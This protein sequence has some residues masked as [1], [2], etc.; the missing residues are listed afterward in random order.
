MKTEE[1]LLA[2]LRTVNKDIPDNPDT[3]LLATHL[4]DSFDMVNLVSDIEEE[5][6]I[7]L[8][9]EDIVPEHFRSVKAMAALIAAYGKGR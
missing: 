8:D 4:I 1:R 9:P 3:D 7:E 5:F 6:D 2:I